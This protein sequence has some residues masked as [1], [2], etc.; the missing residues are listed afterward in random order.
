MKIVKQSYAAPEIALVDLQVKTMLCQSATL[1]REN[2]KEDEWY[3][4]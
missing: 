2:L 3:E 1:D 4:F